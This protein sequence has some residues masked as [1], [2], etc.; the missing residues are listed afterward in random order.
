MK[1]VTFVALLLL[2]SQYLKAADLTQQID[3]LESEWATTYYTT[4]GVLQRQRYEAL[5][6]KAIA[7]SQQFPS[8]AEP[9]I[10]H[11]TVLAS[12]ASTLSS[13]AALSALQ[14][15]K[16]L[17]EQAIAINPTALDGSAYVTLGTLY[18]MVPSWPLS[19]GNNQLAEKMLRI[20]LTINPEGIDS[21][22]FYADF[23]RQ[24]DKA[25]EATPYFLKAA[26]A[27]IRT[28][29]PLADS[30]LQQQAKRAVTNNQ[31]ADWYCHLSPLALASY[32]A[33]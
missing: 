29:Q 25:H 13:L 32:Q 10:W 30:H 20:G 12:Q 31:Q 8:A 33:D 3:A 2:C 9:K 23:L 16:S 11:A 7:L 4:S 15:A 28:N 6:D 22:Y 19:F 5:L 1:N 21:N 27:P 18:Y 14:Q 17:L 24:Q 26:A